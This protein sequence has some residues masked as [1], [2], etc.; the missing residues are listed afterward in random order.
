MEG[1]IEGLVDSPNRGEALRESEVF[2]LL[3]KTLDLVI[4]GGQVNGGEGGVH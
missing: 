3:E 1:S 2:Q 4:E